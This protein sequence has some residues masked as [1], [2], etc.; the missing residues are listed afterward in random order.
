M[1][2][3]ALDQADVVSGRVTAANR[4][5]DLGYQRVWRC[6]GGLVQRPGA[7]PATQPAR[8]RLQQREDAVGRYS[9]LTGTANH[10]H[11]ALEQ[12][13]CSLI[14]LVREVFDEP[15]GRGQV[16]RVAG[17]R[18]PR[19]LAHHE[20]DARLGVVGRHAIAERLDRWPGGASKGNLV[21]RIQ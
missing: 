5:L 6:I 14:C 15:R 1:I 8:D 17:L 20:I 11:H 19:E 9:D 21:A 13:T 10:R 12:R 16:P 3:D 4:V 18:T 2:G 7:E